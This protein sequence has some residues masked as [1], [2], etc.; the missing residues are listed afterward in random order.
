MPLYESILREITAKQAPFSIQVQQAFKSQYRGIPGS[1]QLV[2]LKL[3]SPVLEALREQ[4]ISSLEADDYVRQCFIARL[5][6]VSLRPIITPRTDCV[7]IAIC[8]TGNAVN[9]TF[10]GVD[11]DFKT[12]AK[13][14][15]ATGFGIKQLYNRYIDERASPHPFLDIPFTGKPLR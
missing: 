10:R 13:D 8:A 9:R 4:I 7:R 12:E 2:S 14:L 6:R 3:V 1:R 11:A 5:Q 15:I